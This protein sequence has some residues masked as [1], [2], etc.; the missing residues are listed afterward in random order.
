MTGT[1]T[2]QELAVRPG[3]RYE[4]ALVLALLIAAGSAGVA[5]SQEP[6]ASRPA[7][8][9]QPLS[10]QGVPNLHRIT[11]TLY[12]SAQPT[13][14]GMKNLER[15]GVRTV[16]NLRANHSDRQ[17]GADTSLVLRRLE[18][19][20]WS[21][22]QNEITAVMRMLADPS[23]APYLLHCQHGADRT[24]VMSAAFRMVFQGWS[25]G[26]AIRE[27]VGGGYGFH[28]V[29]SNLLSLLGTLD[30]EKIR[31]EVTRDPAATA[32]DGEPRPAQAAPPAT[33]IVP[34]TPPTK[35][36]APAAGWIY[37]S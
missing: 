1:T 32:P 9:A 11:D 14:E 18:T 8:W 37:P 21:L 27:M 16:I 25:R 19:N 10:L 15:L 12:R 36:P 26:E 35:F 22:D 3:C 17:E 30:I 13:A 29:W 7:A 31:R 6:A 4:S 5:R 23:G 28:G 2:R 20:T 33:G 24:G 34:G